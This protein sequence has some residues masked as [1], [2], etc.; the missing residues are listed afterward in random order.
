MPSS[1]SRAIVR[2]SFACDSACVFCGQDGRS[3]PLEVDEQQLA[4]VREQHDELTF[5]GGEP[6]LDPRLP[7]AIATARALGFT[8]IG[9]QTNGWALATEP[10]LFDS[11]VE[12]G[13]S[14]L[15]LSIHGPTAEAHDFHTGRPGSFANCL[16]I[17]ARGQRANLPVVVTTIVTRS[18]LRE[19]PKL[20][21]LLK[22]R[23]V[24]AWLLQPVRPYGRAAD[25]FARIVPRFGMAIPW[26]LHALEQARRHA[27][28]AWIRGAPLCS[29]G[30]F[31]AAALPDETASSPGAYA[32][33]CTQ[34]PAR[35]RCGGVDPAY[36]A[37]FGGSELRP[38][39]ARPIGPF[40][41]G[42][43]RLMRMF[44]GVG[45]LVE[46]P[47]Q[48]RS[49]AAPEAKGESQKALRLPVLPSDNDREP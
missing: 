12:A 4:A 42:R 47:P 7:R 49:P 33:A 23:G 45:E 20:P 1:E 22:R 43:Q 26:A 27:L 35:S 29:L 32:P 30:P 46:R 48:L 9:L 15:H 16:E 36:L 5:V 10:G 34:C 21:P 6:A 44:V 17:L 18:N 31:A 39:P 40:D 8:A 37:V 38:G 2:L 25:G 41:Q 11:L 19:L 3:D 13:L 14:D 28:S 24:S